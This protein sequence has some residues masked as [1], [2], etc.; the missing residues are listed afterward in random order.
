MTERADAG[1]WGVAGPMTFEATS[2]G[3][4][5]PLLGP[6]CKCWAL[7]A[8]FHTS[9]RDEDFSQSCHQHFKWMQTFCQ[10]G[11]EDFSWIRLPWKRGW[12]TLGGH[13]QVMG[14]RALRDFLLKSV[15]EQWIQ[16]GHAGTERNKH[17]EKHGTG[18]SM[19]Q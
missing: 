7:L 18:V 4:R 13:I 2:Q 8:N 17:F 1:L 9:L 19:K 6:S 11:P 10:S 5:A 14:A 3:Q 16:Q 15:L 12:K